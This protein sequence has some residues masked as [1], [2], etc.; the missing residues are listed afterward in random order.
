MSNMEHLD[1]M[2]VWRHNH[3][4]FSNEELS[5][6]S[7]CGKKREKC[8]MPPDVQQLNYSQG[9]YKTVDDH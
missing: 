2:S 4:L 6:D 3:Q 7:K 1:S 5:L 9:I 8:L